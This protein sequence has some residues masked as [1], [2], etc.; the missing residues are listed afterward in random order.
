MVVA[1]ATGAAVVVVTTAESSPD[2]YGKWPEQVVSHL[3]S[4]S[5]KTRLPSVLCCTDPSW[6][7]TNRGHIAAQSYVPIE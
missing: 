6:E 2:L 3:S 1:A 4:S 7:R 5:S